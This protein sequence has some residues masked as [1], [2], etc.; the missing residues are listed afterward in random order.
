MTVADQIRSLA[1]QGLSRVEIAR[2]LGKSY[3]HVRNVLEG[4]RQRAGGGAATPPPPAHPPGLA[5]PAAPFGKTYRL[6][7]E[8]GGVV[9]LPPEVL[10]VLRS[11]AGGVLIS[12][13]E[14]DRLVILST[15]AAW[16]RVQDR[17]AARGLN[18]GPSMVDELIA[19]RRAE[20]ARED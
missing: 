11:G 15:P 18:K 14:E 7:V 20:A 17:V 2:R 5:E 9:R 16:K 10:A 13:L 6:D 8:E 1:A 3:Q 19:E 12:E 4:D